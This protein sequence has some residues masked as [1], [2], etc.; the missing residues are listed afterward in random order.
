V[1]VRDERSS[2][3]PLPTASCAA[4][5]RAGDG[6]RAPSDLR[7]SRAR[8][9]RRCRAAVLGVP[10]QPGSVAVPM[11]CGRRIKRQ[12]CRALKSGRWMRDS[13]VGRWCHGRF[14]P[15]LAGPGLPRFDPLLSPF[16]GARRFQRRRAHGFPSILGRCRRSGVTGRSGPSGGGPTAIGLVTKGRL[17]TGARRRVD[18]AASS[19]E[20]KRAA[21]PPSAHRR[22]AGYAPR[23]AGP[24][25]LG[26]RPAVRWGPRR[27]IPCPVQPAY[28]LSV[29]SRAVNAWPHTSSR[30]Y[31]PCGGRNVPPAALPRAEDAFGAPGGAP[32]FSL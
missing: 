27:R 19:P 29:T 30:C 3:R 18:A 11:S 9:P 6:D 14:R 17:E 7:P 5:W 20:E 12:G 2:V 28:R 15:R 26:V 25:L 4:W 13:P 23:N 32:R 22:A 21:A 16:P 8:A 10:S 24:A 1:V 31:P